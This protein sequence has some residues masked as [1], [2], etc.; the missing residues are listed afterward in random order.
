MIVSRGILPPWRLSSCTWSRSR[1]SQATLLPPSKAEPAC[2]ATVPLELGPFD[3]EPRLGVSSEL[4][5]EA[6]ATRLRESPPAEL[7]YHVK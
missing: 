3:N 6:P 4:E 7:I 5:D 1:G 2:V